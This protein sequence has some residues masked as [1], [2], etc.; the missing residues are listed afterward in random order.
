MATTESIVLS[1]IP[2]IN[3]KEQSATYTFGSVKI[4]PLTSK[5]RRIILNRLN[6]LEYSDDILDLLLSSNA[7]FTSKVPPKGDDSDKSKSKQSSYKLYALIY[8]QVADAYLQRLR[9]CLLLFG[10]V[11]NIYPRNCWFTMLAHDDELDHSSIEPLDP[12]WYNNDLIDTSP[13]MESMLSQLSKNW[14]KLSDICQLEPL[15]QTFTDPQ[16]E[17]GYGKAAKKRTELE[18][19][20]IAEEQAKDLSSVPDTQPFHLTFS[21]EWSVKQWVKGYFDAYCREVEKLDE[22]LYQRSAAG[23]FHRAFQSFVRGCEVNLPLNFLA[24]TTALESLFGS[25]SADITYQLASRISWLLSPKKQKDRIDLFNQVYALYN[26]RSR[27][28]HGGKYK[29]GE[30]ENNLTLI[31]KICRDVF[32]KILICN[33]LFLAL[34]DTTEKRCPEVLKRLSLG[35]TSVL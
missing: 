1:P 21:K 16:K 22:P 3:L 35:D 31:T 20:K 17:K 5:F 34:S 12:H 24:F 7:I 23:R 25:E 27:I 26:Y 2:Q 18:A 19:T 15:I 32:Q 4:Q 30:F 9:S 33:D 14:D 13:Y 28:V 6:E 8:T 11:H 10:D 29:S